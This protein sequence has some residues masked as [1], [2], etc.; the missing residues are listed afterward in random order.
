MAVVSLGRWTLRRRDA[1]DRHRNGSGVAVVTGG[2]AGVGRA[3]V[4]QLVRRG[5]PVAVLARGDDGLAATVAEAE[6]HGGRVLGISVDVADSDAVER[7]ASDV[8]SALGPIDVWINNAMT[9]V[10]GEFVDIAPSDF[11]RVT[12]VTYLGYV[13]GTRA[14]LARMMPRGHG[15]IVQVGSALAYRGIPLESAYC[16]AKHAIAGF[17]ESVRAELDHRNGGVHL[18]DVHLPAVNTP[19][20]RWVKSL[21]PRKSQPVPPIYQPEVAADAIVW[22]VEHPRRE[23]WV[24]ASTALTVLCDRIAPRL[25]D[26]YLARTGFEAQQLD[27]PR[28]RDRP[29]N[30]DSPVAG[31]HGAHGEFDARAHRRSPQLWLSKRRR[32]VAAAAAGVC[33]VAVVVRAPRS[34]REPRPRRRSARSSRGGGRRPSGS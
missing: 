33:A 1:H 6:E 28:D 23:R 5:W 34:S 7:A 32:V 11:E 22:T 25:L 14:A 26:R 19:Q 15:T 16:A 30:L 2:S 18:C 10:F 13:N 12:N 20:F 8:E 4:R 29:H 3:T 9:S 21:L 27:E 17:N 31:D 24:G